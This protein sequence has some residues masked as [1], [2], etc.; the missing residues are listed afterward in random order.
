MELLASVLLRRR[1]GLLA[2][3]IRWIQDWWYWLR[4]SR[5][6]RFL[7]S[8]EPLARYRVHSRSTGVLHKHAYCEDRLKILRRIL[9]EYTDLS[10]SAKANIV[11]RMGVDLCEIGNYRQGH[12]LLWNAAVL[13]IT[14]V[15]AFSTF[16]RAMRRIIMYALRGAIGP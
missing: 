4:L 2:E 3:G 11:F 14:D 13:S 6:H 9:R 12:Q 7:F 15:R 10:R 8:E 5:Y 1:D 16:C